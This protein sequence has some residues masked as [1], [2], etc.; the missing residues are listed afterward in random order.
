MLKVGVCGWWL[1]LVKGRVEFLILAPLTF[2]VVGEALIST[3]P[4]NDE[5]CLLKQVVELAFHVVEVIGRQ[6]GFGIGLFMGDGFLIGEHNFNIV[7]RRGRE[8]RQGLA[9]S[10]VH[11]QHRC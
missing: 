4:I 9:I 7:L 8:V 11:R 2:F 1:F 5:F 6:L 10:G 3:V